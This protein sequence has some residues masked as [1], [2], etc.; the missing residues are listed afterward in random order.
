MNWEAEYWKLFLQYSKLW[1]Y[2]ANT[3][4]NPDTDGD[5]ASRLQGVP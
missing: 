1:Q 3:V 2:V 4:I 5:C